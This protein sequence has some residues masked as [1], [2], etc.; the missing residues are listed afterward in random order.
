[1]ALGM[2]G[3]VGIAGAVIE[4]AEIGPHGCGYFVKDMIFIRLL[5]FHGIAIG[6]EGLGSGDVLGLDIGFYTGREI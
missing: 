2:D 3:T 4:S 5:N 1:M 6:N